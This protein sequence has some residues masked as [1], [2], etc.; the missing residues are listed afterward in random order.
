MRDPPTNRGL[1]RRQPLLAQKR[2]THFGTD[3]ERSNENSWFSCPAAYHA[4]DQH[5]TVDSET[6]RDRLHGS[7]IRGSGEDGLRANQTL[8]GSGRVFARAVDMPPSRAPV[9]PADPPEARH[10]MSY[11]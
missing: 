9:W 4:D 3:P 2:S 6:T 7:G 1:R 10:V 8:Q 5:C 11:P